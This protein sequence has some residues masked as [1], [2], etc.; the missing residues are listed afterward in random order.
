M[1]GSYQQKG[2]FIL[3]NWISQFSSQICSVL[4]NTHEDITKMFKTILQEANFIDGLD[5]SI[6]RIIQ[7]I[8]TRSDILTSLRNI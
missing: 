4:R 5:S 1:T 6:D 8:K 7:Q 3:I 2:I